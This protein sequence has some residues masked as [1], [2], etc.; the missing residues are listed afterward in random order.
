[1]PPKLFRK[2]LIYL[3]HNITKRKSITP[4]I[5]HLQPTSKLDYILLSL[6]STLDRTKKTA[7]ERH[8]KHHADFFYKLSDS[9]GMFKGDFKT[10][11][12]NLAPRSDPKNIN[13]ENS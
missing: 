6:Y 1:M 2:H 11:F 7:K 10:Y 13:L 12:F 5:N 9:M 3:V 4:R 8:Y